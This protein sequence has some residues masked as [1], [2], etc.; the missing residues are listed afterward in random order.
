MATLLPQGQALQD[1][2]PDL[3]HFPCRAIEDRFPGAGQV[4]AGGSENVTNRIDML[5]VT[6]RLV[7][8]GK[9]VFHLSGLDSSGQTELSK[10]HLPLEDYVIK[11]R[12]LQQRIFSKKNVCVCQKS[13]QMA[14]KGFPFHAPVC[15]QGSLT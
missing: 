7:T 9:M 12:P 14:V 11:H 15:R 4:P 10:S 1:N 2:Y 6:P 8:V 3:Y 5:K 13:S